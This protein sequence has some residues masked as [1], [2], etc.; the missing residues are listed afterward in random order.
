MNPGLVQ[1]LPAVT[2]LQEKRFLVANKRATSSSSSS[3]NSSSSS[4]GRHQEELVAKIRNPF[5]EDSSDGSCQ[6]LSPTR[7][8]N[9]EVHVPKLALSSLSR[10]STPPLRERQESQELLHDGEVVD[11]HSLSL[12]SHSRK[13]RG[14]RRSSRSSSSIVETDLSS[15]LDWSDSNFLWQWPLHQLNQGQQHGGDGSTPVNS[16]SA[17]QLEARMRQVEEE[18]RLAWAEDKQR[19]GDDHEHRKNGAFLQQE[20]HQVPRSSSLV[21]HG[22]SNGNKNNNVTPLVVKTP[23]EVDLYGRSSC[24]SAGDRTDNIVLLDEEDDELHDGRSV[25]ADAAPA[26]ARGSLVKSNVVDLICEDHEAISLK[27]NSNYPPFTSR[28]HSLDFDVRS[29]FFSHDDDNILIEDDASIVETTS[30]SEDLLDSDDHNFLYTFPDLRATTTSRTASREEIVVPCSGG[31]SNEDASSSSSDNF[32]LR[33]RNSTTFLTD[34]PILVVSPLRAALPS[35]RSSCARK[36]RSASCAGFF[37]NSDGATKL[38]DS[39]SSEQQQL[40]DSKS[41]VVIQ[42]GVGGTRSSSSS[43]S[44]SCRDE[45]VYPPEDHVD[46]RS[47]RRRACSDE[48]DSARRTTFLVAHDSNTVVTRAFPSVSDTALTGKV[49]HRLT[50]DDDEAGQLDLLRRTLTGGSSTSRRTTRSASCELYTSVSRYATSTKRSKCLARSSTF[51]NSDEDV[52]NSCNTTRRPHDRTAIC[53]KSLSP[54]ARTTAATQHASITSTLD[55]RE[56]LQ[57]PDGLGLYLAPPPG[58]KPFPLFGRRR[59]S[60]IGVGNGGENEVDNCCKNEGS[61]KSSFYLQQDDPKTTTVSANPL[62]SDEEAKADF[63]PE[64]VLLGPPSSCATESLFSPRSARSCTTATGNI[65]GT[66]KND[67]DTTS[68]ATAPQRTL[69]VANSLQ[70]VDNVSELPAS[71]RS[72]SGARI[73]LNDVEDN[74]FSTDDIT[75]AALPYENLNLVPDGGAGR[76]CGTTTS[77][78]TRSFYRSRRL[79]KDTCS[80]SCS[81]SVPQQPALP[82]AGAPTGLT[83]STQVNTA[84]RA[85]ESST[86]SSRSGAQTA[87]ERLPPQTAVLAQSNSTQFDFVSHK[88]RAQRQT[89]A[90]GSLSSRG[91]STTTTITTPRGGGPPVVAGTASSAGGNG[92]VQMNKVATTGYAMMQATSGTNYSSGATAT[93]AAHQ[94]VPTTSS[95]VQAFDF[96]AHR[97]KARDTTAW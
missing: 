11:Q 55:G 75:T 86:T 10:S 63:C 34:D 90:G 29:R 81:T 50:P 49:D 39:S 44:S 56:T 53:S 9:Q 72:T 69:S 7:I 4:P 89:I 88:I 62:W 13:S 73:I 28:D 82:Q 57:G 26:G 32:H 41:P 22:T 31:V 93:A 83:T 37:H 58:C 65:I 27:N 92:G 48:E 60:C 8:L 87:R 30:S 95:N 15:D 42:D 66:H 17:A 35:A 20:G 67:I 54:S 12:S 77:T 3:S 68:E 1:Q 24:T 84:G 43:S 2:F 78:A 33:A 14:S 51:N 16:A 23:R 94:V 5:A 80:T 52:V 76:S 70:D 36:D 64:G 19:G 91:C 59:S 38:A 71:P 74:N 18:L 46:G 6:K 47:R 85:A 61:P 45:D 96:T 25:R 40:C 79:S 97:K 21:Y